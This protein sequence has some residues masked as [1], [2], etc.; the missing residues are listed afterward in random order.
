MMNIQYVI[1]GHFDILSDVTVR[2]K[3][4]EHEVIRR[5]Y[6]PTLK[7]GGVTGIVASLFV[8]S[9][10]LPYGALDTAM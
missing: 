2:R 9:Q 1:D 8:D 10:Y 5:L 7:A 4:G 3:K 6:Y